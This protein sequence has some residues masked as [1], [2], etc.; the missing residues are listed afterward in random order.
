MRTLVIGDIHGCTRAFDTLLEAVQPRPGDRLITLGDYVDR[1]PDARGAIDRLLQLGQ[2]LELVSLRGN[3][4]WMMCEARTDPG[5]YSDWL[6][7]GGRET[8]ASYAPPGC[9]GDLEHVPTAH[10]DFLDHLVDYFETDTH[11]FVHALAHAKLS[12]PDQP[13]AF[14]HWH[15]LHPSHPPH[16]SGKIMVCGHTAQRS[17]VPLNL[18]HAIC[19]DTWVYGPGWLTCLELETGACWQAKQDGKLRVSTL[20][21]LTA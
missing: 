16:D 11:F 20:E 1:G 7:F 19:L 2:T 12:L 18:G 15:K 5:V 4:D 14:L 8:L 21:D 3:H 17:G 9:D 6:G 10:W 13:Q